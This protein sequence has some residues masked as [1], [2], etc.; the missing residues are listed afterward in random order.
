MDLNIQLKG[1]EKLMAQSAGFRKAVPRVVLNAIRRPL[2]RKITV[3]KR[4]IRNECGIG[5]SIWGA[6]AKGLDTLVTL[7][8]AKLKDQ[9]IVTGIKLR[10]IPSMIEGGG[11]FK[12][13]TIKSGFGR[14]P[15]PHPGANVRPHNIAR[16]EVDAAYSEILHA[17]R[18]D[19]TK[20]IAKNFG[21][22][23]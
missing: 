16:Q 21:S 11:R 14:G 13:H 1:V 18:E 10:G 20:Q 15:I 8:K 22:A 17:V 5:A 4:R 12:P 7:I 3:I 9:S 2:R 6:K 19:I 23:A